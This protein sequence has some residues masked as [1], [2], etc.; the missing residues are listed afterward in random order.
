MSAAAIQFEI[1]ARDSDARVGR[2]TTAHG[3]ISTPAFMPVGT[4]AAVKAMAP[5]EL[6]SMGYRLVLANAY[7]LAVRPGAELVQHMGGVARFMGFPGAVLTDSGGFQAMSLAKINSI[8]DDGISFRSHLDGARINLSPAGAVEIQEQLG[9]DIMM[10]LDECT[11]YPAD[12]GRARQSLELTSRW[13]ERSLAARRSE[14]QALFGI[15][16]G[17]VFSD[18]RRTSARQITSLDFDGFAAGGLSVGEP[19]DAMREMAALSATLLPAARPRYLMGVGTPEDLLAA[20]AMGYDMFDCVLP[21]RNARNGGA[22][23]SEGR[24]AIKRA[25]YARDPRPLDPDCACR[26][27]ANLSRAYLRHLHLSGEILA[28]RAITEHNL[29]YYARLM[30]DA[31]AAIASRTFNAYAGSLSERFSTGEA[32]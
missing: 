11:P 25:E 1:V 3:E 20:I 30:R 21:T 10:A 16:Q 8:D 32:A 27:C 14:H 22:F 26:T 28:A 15:V 24:V 5:D 12:H 7:H 6:W 19:K 23:T 4:R 2:L 18:L 31:Q 29:F 9:A 17:S 13:A